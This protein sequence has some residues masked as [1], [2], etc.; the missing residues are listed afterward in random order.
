M[1]VPDA[2]KKVNAF[3]DVK[4]PDNRTLF[5]RLGEVKVTSD[6]FTGDDVAIMNQDKIQQIEDFKKYA[7]DMDSKA[8]SE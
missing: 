8:K 4:I 7:E 5:A 6:N 3:V 2:L 1:F